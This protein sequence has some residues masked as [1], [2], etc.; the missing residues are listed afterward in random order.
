MF[1]QQKKL[2]FVIIATI[3]LAMAVACYIKKPVRYAVFAGYNP[4]GTIHPYVITYLK[5]LNEVADGVVY[6][7][8]STLE[9]TEEEKLKQLTIH[10]ENIRHEEYDWGSYKRGF[11]WLKDNGYLEKADEIILANDSCYAPL[12]TF[13][14]MF[15]A[16]AKRKD[17]DF[18]GDLQNTRFNPHVQSYFMVF[19]KNVF[20]AR[21]FQ[22]FINAVRHQVDSSLYITAYEVKLTPYLENFGFKW[23]SYMPY[24]ELSYLAD[25]EK[26]SYPLTLVKKYGHQFIKRRIFKN[27]LMMYENEAEL[28]RYVYELNPE[29]YFDIASEVPEW[30]IPD[31]LKEK[32]NAR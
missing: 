6:V 23:D 27:S 13:K 10:Y 24:Q 5:G 1:K 15:K 20:N 11:N 32:K 16:M 9:P 2:V 26:N 14:P 8:D 4:D 17:L 19:K 28:L 29:R 12:T 30:F 7:A 31:D 22:H 3:A 18:W 21:Q 25:S